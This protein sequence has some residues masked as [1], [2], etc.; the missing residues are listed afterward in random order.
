M[1]YIDI[2]P[3]ESDLFCFPEISLKFEDDLFTKTNPDQHIFATLPDSILFNNAQIEN[4]N[5][6]DS[7]RKLRPMYLLTIRTDKFNFGGEISHFSPTTKGLNYHLTALFHKGANFLPSRVVVLK[8]FDRVFHQKHFDQAV[9]AIYAT[10][11]NVS[12]ENVLLE[13]IISDYNRSHRPSCSDSSANAFDRL[14]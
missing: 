4:Q 1:I 3:S 14:F 9:S 13:S 11:R 12:F 8:Q 5:L 10:V 2:T 7:V 6:H